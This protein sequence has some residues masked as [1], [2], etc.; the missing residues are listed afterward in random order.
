MIELSDK[1]LERLKIHEGYRDHVYKCSAGF[2]TI[3]FGH[4]IDANPLSKEE[5]EYWKEDPAHCA[6][7]ILRDDVSIFEQKL[8]KAKPCVEEMTQPRIDALINMTFNMGIGWIDRFPKCWR[9]LEAERYAD[10]SDEIRTSKYAKDVGA[11]ASE[12]AYQIETGHYP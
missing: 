11:R 10:A 12:I 2:H 4:N 7:L 6:E 5:K 9:A 3:G 1:G 8:F